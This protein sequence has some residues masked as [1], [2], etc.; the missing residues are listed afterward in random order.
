MT[1][2]SKSHLPKVHLVCPDAHAHPDHNNE[3]FT[4]LG[5]L[6]L[7]LK[8]DVVV[9]IG[10]HA[11]MP[12]LSSYDKGKASF[13]GRNYSADIE[14]ALDA[15]ERTWDPIFKSKKKRPYRVIIEGNHEHR[16]KKMLELEPHLE[17]HKFGVS[18]RDLE[19][20]KYYSDVVEYDGSSPGIINVDGIDYSHY[21]VSGISGRPLQSIHHAFDLTRKRFVSSTVGHSHLFDY[22]VSRDSSGRTRMGLVSGVFQ[23]YRNSWA[24]TAANHWDSGVII[25]R[26]VENGVYDLERISIERLKREYS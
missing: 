17:G 13:H 19:F 21:F 9:N 5:K 15:H 12:S 7:D 11:D 2:V 16:I 6:I 22:H 24:G 18:F 14:S 23:D 3:R 4:W 20:D 1:F 8:P 10:D 25:K 26:N